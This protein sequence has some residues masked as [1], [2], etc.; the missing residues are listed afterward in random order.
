VPRI[1]ASVI[2][3]RLATLVELDT[4]LGIEDCYDLLEVAAVDAY[5]SQQ[6]D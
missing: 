1:I 4:V 3:S 5:N 6:K 2:S